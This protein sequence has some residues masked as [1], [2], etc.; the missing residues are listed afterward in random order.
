MIH[1]VTGTLGGGKSLY[2]ARKISRA[3]LEGKVVATNIRLLDDWVEKVCRHNPY[4]LASRSRSRRAIEREV[5]TRYAY[6]P[7]IEALLSARLYGRGEGRGLMIL[8][9]AHNEINNREWA[10]Q[11]QKVA[12]RKLTLARKRG[13]HAYIISQHKDNTDAA[14]RRIA[15]IEVKCLNWQQL[16]RIPVFGVSPLPFPIFLAQAFAKNQAS[17]VNATKRLYGEL[18]RLGWYSKIYDT[19]EDF[20]IGGED[21]AEDNALWLPLRE[22]PRSADAT[23]FA[24]VETRSGVDSA[25]EGQS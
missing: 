17:N 22:A 1:Y 4:W 11:N 9:E 20:D 5:R 12:L 7:E 3:L 18:Y 24:P 15:T 13:W 6:V 2:A 19:F 23:A 21:G 25:V 10:E 14:L 16:T 8:D